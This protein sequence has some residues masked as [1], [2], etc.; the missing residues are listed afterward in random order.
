[1][2]TTFKVGDKLPAL[3]KLGQQ[4]GAVVTYGRPGGNRAYLDFTEK[5]GFVV[6]LE[7]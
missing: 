4:K 6:E 1:M 3:I 2:Q 5:I 7:K